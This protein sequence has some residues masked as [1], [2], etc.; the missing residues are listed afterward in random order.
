MSTAITLSVGKE[1]YNTNG[2]L[3]RILHLNRPGDPA[4]KIVAMQL[5]TGDVQFF[6]DSGVA[7]NIGHADLVLTIP[8]IPPNPDFPDAQLIVGNMY[9]TR[10][11]IQVRIDSI[12]GQDR[13][14]VKK[15]DQLIDFG[16]E[17]WSSGMKDDLGTET[18]DDLISIWIDP[19]NMKRYALVD[20]NSPTDTSKWSELTIT[21][22]SPVEG[23]KLVVLFLREPVTNTQNFQV[24][25]KSQWP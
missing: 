6:S 11:G 14:R 10:A 25:A 23:K 22:P 1:V 19:I 4:S 3:F 2:H 7:D 12:T 8:G 20:T 16:Y 15:V 9:K 18:P 24:R 5:S 21:K 17:V 13:F